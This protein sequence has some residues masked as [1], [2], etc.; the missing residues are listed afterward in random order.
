LALLTKARI[1]CLRFIIEYSSS[2]R[3]FGHLVIII[4]LF[5]FNMRI[6]ER[7]YFWLVL[8]LEISYRVIISWRILVSFRGFFLKIIFSH[9]E[10]FE[11]PWFFFCLKILFNV[12][13]KATLWHTPCLFVTLSCPKPWRPQQVGVHGHGPLVMF[14]PVVGELWNI[15]KK[16]CYWKFNKIKTKISRN[17]GILLILLETAKRVRSYGGMS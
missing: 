11:F 17:W 4:G 14:R 7:W 9:V 3:D 15:W 16:K 12:N 10:I 8:K 2:L 13:G 5:F 6:F 1:M